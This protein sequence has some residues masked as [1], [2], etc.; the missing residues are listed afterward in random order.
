MSRLHLRT[1]A[2]PTIAFIFLCCASVLLVGVVFTPAP[3]VGAP[4]TTP[5]IPRFANYPAVDSAPVIG[6]QPLTT[7]VAAGD[8][9]TLAV[10]L[11]A[12]SQPTY[13]HWYAGTTELTAIV[14][15]EFI[16]KVSYCR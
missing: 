3:T 11:S 13:Y 10:T 9:A 6:N 15:I 1:A 12:G 16:L 5:G 8:V 7:F 4:P 2:K 14:W